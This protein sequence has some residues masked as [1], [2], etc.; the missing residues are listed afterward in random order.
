MKN[1][2]V[3]IF[4]VMAFAAPASATVKVVAT[5]PW[6][7]SIAKDI[8]QDKISVTTL[9]KTSQD[10]HS[11]EAK[12][13]MI[14][15]ARQ[16]DILMYNGLD[17][18]VGYL[19]ILV[20]SSKNPAIMIGKAGNFNASSYVDAIE[21]PAVNCRC[22]GDVHPL[23]NPHYH[24][25]PKNIKKVAT[26]MG[27]AL[28]AADHANASFYRANAAAFVKKVEQKQKE[29]A[30]R[31]LKKKP[32]FSQHKFFEYLAGEYGFLLLAYLEEKPGIPPS[33]AHI[34]RLIANAAMLHP[35][36]ILT[37]LYH[38]PGPARF[39]STKT[40]VKTV[41]VPHDVGAEGTKDWFSLMDAVFNALEKA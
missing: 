11:I 22:N 7:G 2:L 14:A 31:Q 41:F 25:S 40:G 12:P 3:I 15:A 29:W 10:P 9:V 13:S 8:G 28:A 39:F 32:F 27:E 17:L 33:S 16:A 18:E 19:P 5:L 20:E 4:A 1:I 6:I 36:A 38:G 34:E 30:S 24:L 35:R 26:G 21:K 23:G 37:T